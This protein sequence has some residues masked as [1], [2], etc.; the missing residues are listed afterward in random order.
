MRIPQLWNNN[1]KCTIYIKVKVYHEVIR[2]H[3]GVEES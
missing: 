3:K 1:M 2:K